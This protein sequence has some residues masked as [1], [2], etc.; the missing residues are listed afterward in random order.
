MNKLLLLLFCLLISILPSSCAV[1]RFGNC[2]CYYPPNRGNFEARYW[3]AKSVVTAYVVSR[4]P[5]CKACRNPM[6]RR[7][8]IMNYNLLVYR[9]F[10]G[11][12]PGQRF[13]AQAYTNADYCG[14]KLNVDNVYLLNLHDP[15]SISKASP[16]RQGVYLLDACQGH[17]AWSAVSAPRRNWLNVRRRVVRMA[18]RKRMEKGM[19]RNLRQWKWRARKQ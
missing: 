4:W 7:N 8:E 13:P 3:D 15:R 18:K 1:G 16:F 10:K 19:K 9:L 17:W 11:I 2:K 5:Q 6:D 12:H 14:V